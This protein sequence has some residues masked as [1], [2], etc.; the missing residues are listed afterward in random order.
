M[1]TLPFDSVKLTSGYLFGKQELNRKTTIYS[2]YDRFDES[3]R[4]KAFEFTYD[5]N[6]PNAIQP[7]YFWDSDLAKWIESVAYIIKND[8][9][10]DRSLEE[11]A[12]A[13]IENIK[14]HQEENGYF[15]IYFT[16]VEPEST[17]I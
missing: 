15:N 6:D 5:K 14:K 1:K 9:D 10:Y 11:K 3:G 13:I 8:P 12:D 4:V 7:H 2:V 17:P 16:V